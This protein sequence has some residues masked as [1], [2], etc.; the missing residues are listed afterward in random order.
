MLVAMMEQQGH[1]V[2]EIMR[3]FFTRLTLRM[4]FFFIAQALLA[5]YAGF[6][7]STEVWGLLKTIGIMVMMVIYMLIEV[8]LFRWRMSRWSK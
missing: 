2:N 6:Y 3:E 8:V 5:A 7:W 4:G 1:S